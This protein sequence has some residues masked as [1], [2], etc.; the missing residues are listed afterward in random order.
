MT[1]GRRTY[2]RRWGSMY[3]EISGG[4][5]GI[6]GWRDR[7]K[8]DMKMT[9]R[10]RRRDRGMRKTFLNKIFKKSQESNLVLDQNKNQLSL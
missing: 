6:E 3:G 10:R 5:E 4:R 2:K 1:K 8:R 9:N 7:E